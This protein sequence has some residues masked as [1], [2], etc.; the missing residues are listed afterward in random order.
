MTDPDQYRV[1]AVA[2]QK[3]AD[4]AGLAT[5]RD[6][7]TAAAHRWTELA[8]RAEGTDPIRLVPK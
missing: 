5:V 6:R 2:C 4:E 1:R 7:W 8:D 3:L